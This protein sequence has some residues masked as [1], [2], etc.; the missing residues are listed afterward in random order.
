MPGREVADSSLDGSHVGAGR[1][2]EHA[3]PTLQG[4]QQRTGI[5]KLRNHGRIGVGR[6]LDPLKADF[7]ESLHQSAFCGCG[8]KVR[9]VLQTVAGE[10]FTQSDVS[11]W[12]P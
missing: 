7:G 11:H 5:G 9:F 4:R 2:V 12:D 6:R 3:G 1:F 10:A 8:Q